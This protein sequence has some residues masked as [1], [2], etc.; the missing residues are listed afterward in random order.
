VLIFSERLD[1]ED[2]EGMFR[3]A[4][5]MGLEGIVAKKLTSKYKPG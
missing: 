2:G 3:H 5:S 1:G 4:C